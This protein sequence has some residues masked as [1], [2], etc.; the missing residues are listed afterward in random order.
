MNLLALAERW[1]EAV[2]QPAVSYKQERC[3]YTADKFAACT[4]CQSICPVGAI[5]FGPPPAF[6]ADSCQQCR[7]CLPVCPVGAYAAD[8]EVES[9]L[10]CAAQ[11]GRESCE[12]VCELNPHAAFGAPSAAAIRVRGCLA[13]LGIGA[14]LALVDQGLTQVIVRLEACANC[15][16]SSLRAQVESQVA[17]ARHILAAWDQAEKLVCTGPEIIDGFK[18]R[19]FW[20]AGSPPISRRNLFRLQPTE[21]EERVS[22]SSPFRERLRVL[23]AISHRPPIADDERLWHGLGFALITVSDE[24]TACG[25]CSRAC[26]TGALQM[27]TEGSSFQLLFTPPACI[28]CNI[29]HHVCNPQA[30]TI[31]HDLT[32]DQIIRAEAD[33]IVQH[34][35]LTHCAKCRASFTSKTG[36]RL[37]PTCEFRRQHPFGSVM[38]PALAAN[39]KHE[40]KSA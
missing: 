34:G 28:D 27:V 32:Y 20:N 39:L 8:D 10:K 17:Q 35:E 24:C 29:C 16:W 13:G 3:L 40:E 33:Q 6:S 31:S 21:K 15:P 30:I 37:C 14:Y 12:I 23:Q 1:G 36:S 22:I 26:P 5:Q 4:A 2:L 9:L 19:P 11:L 18:K 7:A 25:V 38:P